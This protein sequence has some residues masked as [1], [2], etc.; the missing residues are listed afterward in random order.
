MSF[1]SFR[2]GLLVVY[3]GHLLCLLFWVV[4]F[5][6]GTVFAPVSRVFAGSLAS[7]RFPL[8]GL[9]QLGRRNEQGASTDVAVYRKDPLISL[10]QGNSDFPGI[11][12]RQ[13]QDLPGK[14]G[15]QKASPCV[16]FDVPHIKKL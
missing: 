5:F 1:C 14:G 7:C 16:P 10:G 12:A 6:V 9:R 11:W 2:L 3:L 15:Q 4:V 13:S 8:V